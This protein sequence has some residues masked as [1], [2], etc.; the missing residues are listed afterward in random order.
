MKNN[1]WENKF[2]A[3]FDQTF[4]FT[5]LVSCDGT[6]TEV[7]KTALEFAGL[8]IEDVI[9]IKI[10]EAG[11]WSDKNFKQIKLKDYVLK[12]SSGEFVRYETEIK[13]IN[14]KKS[15]IDFSLKPVFEDNGK[16]DQLIAEGRDITE[17]KNYRD[18]LNANRKQLEIFVKH[19]PAAVAMFDK[20]MTYIAA[21][22]RW[23]IDYEIK[24]KNIIGKTHYEIFP[25]IL[26]S[27]EWL[28]IHKKCLNGTIKKKDKDFF[29][30]ENNSI[31]WLKWEIHPWFDS[32]GSVGGIIMFTE[33][34][35]KEVEAEAEI[36]KQ[37]RNA[38]KY[39]NLAGT[40]IAAF[41]KSGKIKL[42]NKKGCEITGYTQDEAAGLD[43]IENF[44]PE[45]KRS[46]VKNIFN[47][48]VSGNIKKFENAQSQ[49]LTKSGK[50]RTVSW[51]NTIIYDDDGNFEAIMSSGEDITDKKNAEKKI[52][53]QSQLLDQVMEAVISTDINGAL[54]YWNKGAEKLFGYKFEEINQKH[55]SLLSTPDENNFFDKEIF[56]KFKKKD[57]FSLE[58]ILLKKNGKT[59]Y[60]L[61]SVSVKKNKKGNISGIICSIIDISAR[62]ESEKQVLQLNENLEKRVFD[63]TR[64]LENANSAVQ[65]GIKRARLIK[66]T[67]SAA[68]LSKNPFSA[69]EEVLKLVCKYLNFDIGHV[70]LTDD[71]NKNL[72]VPSNIWYSNDLKKFRNFVDV[73]METYFQKAVG[74]PGIIM[75][76][77]QSLWV[78][79]IYKEIKFLRSKFMQE[80]NLIS[81]VGFP[82]LTEGKTE[83][84]F[85]FYST[86]FK[87]RDLKLEDTLMEAGSQLG[88][89]LERHKIDFELKESESKF[90]AIF[91][92]S[93]QLL[94]LLTSTGQILNT[95]KTLSKITGS[96]AE[97]YIGRYIWEGREW[98]E[99]D[100]KIKLKNYVSKA[101]QGEIINLETVIKDKENKTRNIDFSLIPVKNEIG[102]VTYIIPEGIDITL[103]RQAENQLAKLA[104]AVQKTINGVIITDRFG[105]I[106]WV[107]QGFTRITGYSLE[108]CLNKKPGSFLQGEKTD[109]TVVAK[110][111]NA[112]KSKQGIKTSL[113]NYKKN[114]EEFWIEIDIQPV[115]DE[116]NQLVNFIS[117]ENDITERYEMTKELQKAKDEAEKANEAKG[118]F[119]ANMSHEIRT[120]MNAIIGMTRLLK[121]TVTS[122]RQNDFLNKIELSGNTLLKL[123][124]DILDFSKIEAGKLEIE[125]IMFCPQKVLADAASLL[126][127]KAKEK[128]LLFNLIIDPD[129]P[130]NIYGDPFRLSQIFLNLV[131]NAVKFTE[132]GKIKIFV[133]LISKKDHTARLGFAVQDTGI[134]MDQDSLK[135][136]FNP[137]TQ[138]DMSTTR[139]YGGTGLG[140][141]ISDKLV[142]IMGSSGITVKS[143]IGKGSIF[144]FILEFEYEEKSAL[145]TKK[146][147]LPPEKMSLNLLKGKKILIAEDNDLNIEVAEL[148][149]KSAGIITDIARNGFEAFEKIKNEKYDAVLMDIQMPVLDGYSSAEKIRHELDNEKKDIPIIAMTAHAMERDRK[150]ALEHKIEYYVTKPVNPDLLFETISKA[151]FEKDHVLNI[152]EKI[153]SKDQKKD[154]GLKKFD[155]KRLSLIFQNDIEGLKEILKSFS[156]KYIFF[157]KEFSDFLVNNEKQKALEILHGIKG[158]SGNL[159]INNLYETIKNLE[160]SLIN[161]DLENINK[162][163]QG[164]NKELDEVLKEIESFCFSLENE[165]LPLVDEKEF[166][167]FLNEN[168]ILIK[169]RSPL[170]VEKIENFVKI[171]PERFKEQGME[172][173]EFLKS[174]NFSKALEKTDEIIKKFEK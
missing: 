136:L 37:R 90:R 116:N 73:T 125:K 161:N 42:L 65:E 52:F 51:S 58:S 28:E 27:H 20:N 115:F 2:K 130:S 45:N 3:I 109:K 154:Y 92:N 64:L 35:T 31:D 91:E 33:I 113:L 24:D 160:I 78:E 102:E 18:E 103:R 61:V 60:S 62:K 22:D 5:A 166:L 123:I 19:T 97:N 145:L 69:F 174:Y 32:S 126:D 139:K 171:I 119:L 29:V 100:F 168:K 89:A 34:I 151:L 143:E 76:T 84:V 120:P 114:G 63:R 112:V 101:A 70:Y 41:D 138:A 137:F 150:K 74:L 87:K 140:L 71:K 82:V 127:V 157:K 111:R 93:S 16:V 44:I 39:L 43:W 13:G 170:A 83:A 99:K 159:G 59:F 173:Y 15:F 30:R 49:I 10:W 8:K 53:E 21:S 110:I 38:E 124:E 75:E 121:Q 96:K 54:N 57:A 165:K 1:L 6:L 162:F 94:G 148:L 132:K 95:N 146:T 12:A 48:I 9:G 36:K 153:N 47:T 158:A 107:N 68:N 7:N 104:L 50:I 129:V 67:A 72:L 117:I 135:K 108:E 147:K 26:K 106:E 133:N 122:S 131:S 11:W 23:Y 66:E 56:N 80:Q 4:N 163:L 169:K 55:I 164:F 86:S 17:I 134:G 98:I 172:I 88:Y 149:L 14:G 118:E 79:N 142:K 156:R 152:G 77:H 85:E 40:I 105:F 141:A 128:G 81:A 167:K 25:E 155:E 46:E 144:E